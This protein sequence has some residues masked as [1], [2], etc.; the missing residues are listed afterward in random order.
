MDEIAKRFGCIHKTVHG[1]G[2]G[3]IVRIVKT[4]EEMLRDRGC[5]NVQRTDYPLTC[6]RDASA[7]L[8]GER[9]D[10]HVYI[11][12]DEKVGVK[13]ARMILEKSRD[14]SV[15]VISVDGPTSFTRRESDT[16]QF[17]LA[18]DMC[19]NVTHHSLVPKHNIVS[20]DELAPSVQVEQLPRILDT[21]PI[22]RYYDWPVGTVV[23]VSR[24]Y[25]GHEPIPFYRCVSASS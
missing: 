16:I 20:R 14:V 18:K 17:F 15:V 5:T 19:F 1:D 10:T 21:D 7:V 2:H 4:C 23:R 8:I 24:C 11:C 12:D 13:Y 6:I 3:N 9:P 22:V 25:A